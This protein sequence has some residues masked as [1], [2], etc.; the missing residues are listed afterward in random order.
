MPTVC[1]IC[2][3]EPVTAKPT[4]YLSKLT[5]HGGNSQTVV[6]CIGI[7]ER[8]ILH[9]IAPAAVVRAGLV[10]ALRMLHSLPIPA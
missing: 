4:S 5:G 2:E 10:Y 1:I 6:L 3:R 7:S 9:G 8:G